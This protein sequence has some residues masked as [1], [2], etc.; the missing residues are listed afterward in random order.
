ML[1]S[2]TMIAYDEA[3]TIR[4]VTAEALSALDETG[5][6]GEVLV[7]DD[8]STDGTSSILDEIARA[9]TRVRVIHHGTNRGFSGAMTSALR[10]ARGDWVFLGPA[11]GQLDMHELA[12]FLAA[13]QDADVVVGVRSHRPDP[14][15]RKVL[16]RLFHAIAKALFPMPLA[17]FSLVFLF[18]G[19][20]IRD[21]RIRSR[22]RTATVLPEVLFRANTRGARLL[23]LTVHPRP[24]MGGRAK[25]GRL[26]TAFL[27][28]LE[29]IRI[30]P[31]VRWDE[32]LVARAQRRPRT[33][34]ETLP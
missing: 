5:V 16:S 3:P 17:E 31:L 27:T 10:G 1:V 25:G 11:D 12:R 4:A 8:G 14:F 33:T 21:M 24:R 34:G 2:V 28:L 29:L 13:R 32:M 26:S 6:D 22:P 19:T 18:R 15:G 23:T 30:A 7:V 20:L 9:Q